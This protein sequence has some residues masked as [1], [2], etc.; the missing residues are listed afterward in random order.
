MWGLQLLVI[1][2]TLGTCDNVKDC[3]MMVTPRYQSEADPPWHEIRGYLELA[4]CSERLTIRMQAL[5]LATIKAGS[6]TRVK[7][8]QP[9]ARYIAVSSTIVMA[10]ASPAS[11]ASKTALGT[12]QMTNI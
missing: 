12:A 5:K 3:T 4:G 8:M 7:L 2:T 1:L 11:A 6:V 10:K 9:T